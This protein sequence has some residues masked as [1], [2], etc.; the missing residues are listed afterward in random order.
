MGFKVQ[1]ILLVSFLVYAAVSARRT[2]QLESLHR[3]LSLQ[4]GMLKVLR[5]GI[6]WAQRPLICVSTVCSKSE[7]IQE[8]GTGGRILASTDELEPKVLLSLLSQA[9]KA[10]ETNFVAATLHVSATTA[11]RVRL[12]VAAGIAAPA[13]RST[14][15]TLIGTTTDVQG[16]RSAA[17]IPA[18]AGNRDRAK[19]M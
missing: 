5:E 12:W 7:G 9:Q 17:G 16:E 10:K 15:P 1:A 8:R 13:T 3:R 14:K 18:M 2:T 6:V 11:H 4:D 19:G